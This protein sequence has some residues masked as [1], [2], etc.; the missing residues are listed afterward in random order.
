MRPDRCL[1]RAQGKRYARGARGAIPDGKRR[2]FECLTVSRAQGM[3]YCN[4]HEE[5]QLEEDVEVYDL[6][7]TRAP[8]MTAQEAEAHRAKNGERMAGQLL[9]PLFTH[10]DA[11]LR[12]IPSLSAHSPALLVTLRVGG[13][14]SCPRL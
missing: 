6:G 8:R 10:R 4:T 12:M 5:G 2:D 7:T 14:S 3:Y 13:G 9:L 1:P 11:V